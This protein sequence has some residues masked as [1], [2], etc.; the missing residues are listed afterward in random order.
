MSFQNNAPGAAAADQPA[1]EGPTAPVVSPVG[2]V[3]LVGAGPGDPELLT[4]K[5]YRALQTATLVLYDHLV[6]P[7]VLDCIAPGAERIYV[8]KESSRHTL[9]Q[10]QIIELMVRL[11]RSG[12]NVVRLKGGDG[13]IFGRG[14]EEVQALAEAGIGFDVVPGITAAQG[15]GA[16]VGIPLTHR[17]HAC[18]LVFATGH[19]RE[20]RTVGLDWELLARPRQTVV[21]YMGVG[22][23]PAICS[24]LIA[25]GLPADTPRRR[26]GK[27][28]PAHR[29]LPHG[30][31]G[32]PAR[33][34]RGR[35]G[36]AP[37]THHGGPG[38]ATAPAAG[39]TGHR[40][41]NSTSGPG[42]QRARLRL[43]ATLLF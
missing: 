37:R 34:G 31:P 17:D 26:G 28:H 1:G 35:E 13:Y 40:A 42:S 25:H 2:H 18:T 5:A 15:A 27:R 8:G 6:G 24:Q 16:S 36:A 10:E 39:A 41:A 30:H 38:G 21:I 20:D 11:A 9:P 22:A 32:H 33:P 14:G 43:T 19:L 23:L 3:T 7:A 12:R 4:R 29:A